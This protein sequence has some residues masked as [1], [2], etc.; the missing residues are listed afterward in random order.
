M[1]RAVLNPF[2]SKQKVA[3]L[4]PLI[5]KKIDQLSRRLQEFASSANV[6]SIGTA[7]SALNMDIITEYTMIKGQDNLQIKDFN[8]DIVEAVRGA[9]KIWQWAK[10]ISLLPWLY[11]RIPLWMIQKVSVPMAQWMALQQV[12]KVSQ[13]K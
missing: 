9:T 13:L 10:H 8:H 4:E 1:R 6:L 12:C 2:F 5:E 7:Y 11:E 3:T